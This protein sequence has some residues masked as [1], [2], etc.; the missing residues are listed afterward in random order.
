M[1]R[2]RRAG[3]EECVL[4]EAA[5]PVQAA[6]ET[7]GRRRDGAE[8]QGPAVRP[9]PA[10][11]WSQ[12]PHGQQAA[13]AR[14]PERALRGRSRGPAPVAGRQEGFGGRL[15]GANGAVGSSHLERAHNLLRE[16][17]GSLTAPNPNLAPLPGRGRPAQAPGP[18]SSAWSGGPG[19]SG[20]GVAGCAP[21]GSGWAWE[22]AGTGLRGDQ[23]LA[24][25][26]GGESEGARPGAQSLRGP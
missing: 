12:H 17:P 1:P 25:G 22:P 4:L 11:P 13:P 23:R 6:G 7:Q 20:S 18:R 19:F 10:V 21:C 24:G 14:S 8:N 2:L 26:E 16:S 3:P 9:V 5:A 15:V